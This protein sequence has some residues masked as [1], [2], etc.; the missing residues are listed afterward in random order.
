MK[1]ANIDSHH[2]LVRAHL[3]C[4]ISARPPTNNPQ[5]KF[6]IEALN[7]QSTKTRYEELIISCWK[8][9]MEEVNTLVTEIPRMQKPQRISGWRDEEYDK[10]VAE[11]DLL[12]QKTSKETREQ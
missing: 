4:R 1:G 11:K 9:C 8:Q 12:Y 10:A 7:M 3:R 6:N 5:R 2:Y